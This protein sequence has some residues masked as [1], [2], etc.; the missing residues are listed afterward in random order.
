MNILNPIKISFKNLWSSKFRSFLTI[1]GIIIGTASVIMVASVGQSAQNLIIN[2]LEGIGSNLIVVLPGASD[3]NGPPAAAFGIVTPTLT[4]DDL[5]VLSDGKTIPEITAGAGYVKGAVSVSYLNRS[6]SADLIGLTSDY[7][8]VED[9]KISVGR[10]FSQEEDTNLARVVVLGKDL[11][12]EI[13]GNE[14]PLEKNIILKKQNYKVIGVLEQ[15]GASGFG[16]S[17]QDNAVLVPLKTAQR[18]IL[19]INHLGYIRLKAKNA[20]LISFA[21]E[22]IKIVL[23]DRHNIKTSQE[24][25]FSVRDQASSIKIVKTITDVLRYFLLVIGSISLLV[26]GIGI[27]NIMLIAVNQRIKEVGLRKSLGAK[28]RDIYFQFLV[29]ASTVSLIGGFLGIILGVGFSFLASIIIQLLGYDWKFLISPWS[30]V[31]AVG[32]SILIGIIFGFYPA[33]KA[34][35]ISPMEALRYE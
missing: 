24:D 5:K 1:L 11:A 16:A 10:F 9:S 3:E 30:I 31:V 20:D 23:R 29:E 17:S 27:M 2:Q 33:R 12:E 14:N 19:N 28:K 13:F 26:G 22:N 25:D 7:L 34:S 32:V 21:K 6:V 15:R 35:Q 8:K 4:Y 18:L